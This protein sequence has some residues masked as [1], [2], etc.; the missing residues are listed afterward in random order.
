MSKTSCYY[1]KLLHSSERFYRDVSGEPFVVLVDPRFMLPVLVMR[2]HGSIPEGYTELAA[3]IGAIREVA[4]L[5]LGEFFVFRLEA[6]ALHFFVRAE[7]MK[8]DL[9]K[10]S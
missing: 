4:R 1:C 6:T 3:S 9:G 8:P 5:V 10:V 7:P 2:K